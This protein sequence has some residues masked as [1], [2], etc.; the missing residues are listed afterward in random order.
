MPLRWATGAGP[1]LLAGIFAAV[2]EPAQVE[3]LTGSYRW[4]VYGLAAVL[5]L[6]FHRSRVFVAVLWLSALDWVMST[7]PE[8]DLLGAAGGVAV[9]LLAVLSL[10]RDRGVASSVGLGQLGASL[11]L[12][13]IP[14]LVSTLT[15]APVKDDTTGTGPGPKVRSISDAQHIMGM[16]FRVAFV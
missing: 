11:L 15:G 16:P 1:I 10:S 14:A 12:A 9:V 2:L 5:S 7:A 4:G 8:T 3:A 6:G 13:G